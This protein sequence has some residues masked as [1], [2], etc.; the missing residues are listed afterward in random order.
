MLHERNMRAM[1]IKF[2]TLTGCSTW[3]M[4][5]T[6]CCWWA[7]QQ[8]IGISISLEFHDYVNNVIVLVRPK[9]VMVYARGTTTSKTTLWISLALTWF[10]DSPHSNQGLVKMIDSTTDHE[11]QSM[12]VSSLVNTHTHTRY[13]LWSELSGLRFFLPTLQVVI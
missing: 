2:P 1:R 8:L 10:D 11:E 6:R 13:P 7:Q 4:E 3:I 9:D 12:K 5:E